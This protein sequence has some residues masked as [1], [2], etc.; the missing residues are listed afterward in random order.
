MEN[1]KGIIL[2]TLKIQGFT[3]LKML[4]FNILCFFIFNSSFIGAIQSEKN[5]SAS[6]F[7]QYEHYLNIY[8]YIISIILYF[9]SY[10]ILW[11]IFFEKDIDKNMNINKFFVLFFI[12]I[13]LSGL[14]L[15]LIVLV[16]VHFSKLGLVG[17]IN[18]YYYIPFKF[19]MGYV[20]V[21]PI[22]Q[23]IIYRVKK[24]VR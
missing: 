2:K 11:F 15:N 1:K 14:F 7:A 20:L 4:I 16:V 23:Q 18:D 24:K 9:V 10:N 5:S 12:I 6:F 3:I 19:M 17:F 22:I 13:Y 8:S 21:I